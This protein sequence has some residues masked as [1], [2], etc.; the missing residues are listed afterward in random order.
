M[1][2]FSAFGFEFDGQFPVTCFETAFAQIEL[3]VVAV[4]ADHDLR[5]SAGF[6]T[7]SPVEGGFEHDLFIRVAHRFVK[8]GGRLGLTEYIGDTV[9]A[10]PVACAEVGVSVVVERAPA[11]SA[12]VPGI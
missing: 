10:D 12:G 2:E 11:N 5:E 3:E 8:C 7:G 6:V 4:R 9:I 1:I